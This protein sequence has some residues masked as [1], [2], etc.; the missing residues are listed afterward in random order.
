MADIPSSSKLPAEPKPEGEDS[1]KKHKQH[2]P[3]KIPVSITVYLHSKAGIT[4]EEI[5]NLVEI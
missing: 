2:K 3:G 1:E 4:S 5:E